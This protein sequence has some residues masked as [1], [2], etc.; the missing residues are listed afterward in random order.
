MGFN[1]FFM[2]FNGIYHLIKLRYLLKM[3][4]VIVD[5]PIEHGDFP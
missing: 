2:G 5:F 3:T 1:G 4:I